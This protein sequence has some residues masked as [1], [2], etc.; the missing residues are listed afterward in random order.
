MRKIF[1]FL[2]SFLL[3]GN[4][5]ANAYDM[6]TLA[7]KT[8][9]KNFT[10]KE[11]VGEEHL[12]FMGIEVPYR[13]GELSVTLKRSNR[14]SSGYIIMATLPTPMTDQVKSFFELNP[15]VETWRK[16]IK[17]NRSL[18]AEGTP[19]QESLKSI[20]GNLAANVLGKEMMNYTTV[21]FQNIEPFRR[22]SA[23]EAFLYTTGGNVVYQVGG[24]SYPMYTKVYFFPGDNAIQMM[25]LLTPDEGKNPLVYALDDLSRAAAKEEI[26]EGVEPLHVMLAKQ[27]PA[28]E[29]LEKEQNKK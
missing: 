16:I 17:L 1:G 18:M 7:S 19:L 26:S 20:F 24:L 15:T 9:S 22:L 10:Y 14:F 28:R 21:S 13:T 5:G 3:L 25:A 11:M 12:P 2:L 8:L 27:E 4:L 23:E 6:N 29:A